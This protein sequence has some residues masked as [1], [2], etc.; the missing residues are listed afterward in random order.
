MARIALD[1]KIIEKLRLV[2]SKLN[3][4]TSSV[5]DIIERLCDKT[6]EL[7]KLVMKLSLVSKK[8]T[9][10]D[11][12]KELFYL[13]KLLTNKEKIMFEIFRESHNNH[14][15]SL[16][17]I[18][19]RMSWQKPCTTQEAKTLIDKLGEQGLIFKIEK[20]PHCGTPFY[21]LPDFCENCGHVLILQKKKFKDKRFRPRY[22]IEITD[23]GKSYVIELINSYIYM[24]A[25]FN[26]WN[27][28]IGLKEAS[29]L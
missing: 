28:Y 10:K 23:E 20:C 14:T 13:E 15:I 8:T 7:S 21:Y 24:H 11:L 22:A 9:L 18:I 26:S 25:F 16:K 2:S 5:P 19:K 4:K 17:T 12:F 1:T 3:I 29:E 27:K 6:L